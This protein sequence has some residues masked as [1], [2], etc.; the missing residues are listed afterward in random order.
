MYF[1]FTTSADAVNKS[2]FAFLPSW[3][4]TDLFCLFLIMS[5][6]IS[7]GSLDN[8][9]GQKLLKIYKIKNQFIF[10]KIIF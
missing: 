9:K 8:L 6:G 4:F 5:I 3:N 7:H 10:N 1:F 2:T